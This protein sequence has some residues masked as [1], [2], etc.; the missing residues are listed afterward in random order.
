MALKIPP[1]LLTLLFLLLI[2]LL[3]SGLPVAVPPLPWQSELA[4]FFMVA[5][6]MVCGAGV[7]HFCLQR[8]TMNPRQPGTA[9][10][11]VTT[12][13]YGFSRNPMYL[14]FLLLIIGW[15]LYWAPLLLVLMPL[16]FV[17]YMNRFQISAEEQLLALRFGAEYQRYRQQVRR[18]L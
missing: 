5:G 15:S 18:W 11:L 12:G 3:A 7:I 6:V 14:G 13:V 8:T 4:L 10:R 9:S 1:L 2:W 17:L 16:A